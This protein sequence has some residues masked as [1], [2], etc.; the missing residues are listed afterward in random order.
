MTR[1]DLLADIDKATQSFAAR[2]ME[3]TVQTSG[4]PRPPKIDIT[5]SQSQTT[6]TNI[7]LDGDTP[8]PVAPIVV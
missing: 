7:G 2:I 5:E 4:I 8:P 6:T 1:E 3:Q